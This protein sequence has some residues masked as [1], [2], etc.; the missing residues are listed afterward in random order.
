MIRKIGMAVVAAALTAAA[1]GAAAQDYP[2][3]AV[4]VISPYQSGGT[5]DILGRPF[6]EAMAKH[7][8]RPFVLVNRPGAN[9][10]IGVAATARAPADGYTLTFTTAVSLV[11]NP[12]VQANP[13]YTT[14]DSFDHICQT[15][16][17]EMVIVVR[18][19]SPLKSV[20][21]ILAAGKARPGA[22]SYSNVG[23][24]SIPHLAMYELAQ[25]AG[26]EFNAIP[27]KGGGEVVAQVM[28]GHVDFASAT[29]TSVVKTPVRIVGLFGKQR[30][31]GI[32][33]V[34]TLRELG[35]DVAP[36]SLGGLSA[37]RG[38]PADVRRKLEDACK[39]A[40]HSELYVTAAKNVYQPTDYYASGSQYTS[41]LSEDVKVKGRL[42]GQLGMLK[43]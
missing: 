42:L 35:Y 6:I 16:S 24:G 22:V 40:A 37:P 19:D 38:L 15:F 39:V 17:N 2:A 26:V 11:V 23:T 20:A 8:G 33:D 10:A 3:R 14:I 31:P 13:G 7:F 9:G 34:P 29:L 1:A 27:F 5:T 21:D 4:E 30:N 12:L 36:S 28:G 43:K 32:P 25:V 18:P 41:A